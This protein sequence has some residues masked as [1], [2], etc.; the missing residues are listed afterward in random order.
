MHAKAWAIDEPNKWNEYT[1]NQ[2]DGTE[3]A[4]RNKRNVAEPE[5]SGEKETLIEREN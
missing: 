4:K 5:W 3:R 1:L 2:M